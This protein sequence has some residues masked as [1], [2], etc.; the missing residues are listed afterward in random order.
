[1]DN[2]QERQLRPFSYKEYFCKR[3][4]NPA[5]MS[6]KDAAKALEEF[7]KEH[8]MAMP[9]SLEEFTAEMEKLFGTEEALGVY[10]VLDT[11]HPD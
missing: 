8:G 9:V 11:P 3:T 5:T 1:M 2:N 7:C 10:F 4:H 6:S